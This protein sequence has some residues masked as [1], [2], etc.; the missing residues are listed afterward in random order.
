MKFISNPTRKVLL[1]SAVVAALTFVIAYLYYS[2]INAAEDPRV[3]KAKKHLNQFD[4][5][6]ADNN[7]IA[8]LS[9]LDSAAII[10]SRVKGYEGSFE[11]GVIFNNRASVFIKKALYDSLIS[12]EEKFN[13]LQMAE[14]NVLKSI[15]IYSHWLD[16]VKNMPE[17]EMY[18]ILQ[19][20][21]YQEL[22]G[23]SNKM[24]E[25]IV[26]KRIDDIQMAKIETPRRL[27]VAYTN[28]GII[29]RHQLRLDEAIESY[30]KAVFYWKDNHTARN[31]FNVLM[32]LPPKDRS[33]IE[34][35]FPPDRK[36]V[37]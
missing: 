17:T 33:I 35:L 15:Y 34:Q 13:L 25:K 14:E 28:L 8:A 29:Q 11:M 2:G 4:R 16:S 7:S 5:W 27:S 32:G 3:S 22:N 20:V 6:L 24:I 37:N 23:Y 19:P 36:K 1:V 10:F 21:Y 31:N 12:Q 26:L 18:R 30:K 9:E